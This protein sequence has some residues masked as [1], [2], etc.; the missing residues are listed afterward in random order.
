MYLLV[1]LLKVSDRRDIV[2]F[3]RFLQTDVKGTGDNVFH[4]ISI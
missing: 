4:T 3:T 1:S 2:L